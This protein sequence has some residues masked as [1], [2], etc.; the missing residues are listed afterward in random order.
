VRGTQAA[1]VAAPAAI[2]RKRADFITSLRRFDASPPL[3]RCAVDRSSPETAIGFA[4]GADYRAMMRF[5]LLLA[6]LPLAACSQPFEGR[7][8]D[9]LTEAGLSRP[10]SE[11]MAER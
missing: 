10:M 4:R 9:R 7:I 1:T 11:C 8:A 2:K 5:P 6:L 3:K